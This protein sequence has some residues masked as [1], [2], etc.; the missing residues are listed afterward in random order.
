MPFTHCMKSSIILFVLNWLLIPDGPS[1]LYGKDS[2]QSLS[3]PKPLTGCRALLLLSH[4]FPSLEIPVSSIILCM[5][6][7]LHLLS[8]LLPCL[9]SHLFTWNNS[10]EQE[11]LSRHCSLFPWGWVAPPN[12]ASLVTPRHWDPICHPLISYLC[13]QEPFTTAAS[14]PERLFHKC[15]NQRSL[16]GSP[17]NEH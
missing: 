14:C 10:P 2:E 12:R 9:G 1:F 11:P 5:A 4:L 6:V 7:V 16:R 17:G 13:M 3:I 15:F 8:L